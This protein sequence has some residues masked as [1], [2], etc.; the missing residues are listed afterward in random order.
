MPTPASLTAGPNPVR[1]RA[2]ISYTLPQ[3]GPVSCAV[4]DATGRRVAELFHGQQAAGNQSL[5]WNAAG[6]GPGA[7]LVRIAG[8]ARGTARLVLAE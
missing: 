7:Y 4:Y 5:V 3:A 6:F 8:A 1:S 2:R